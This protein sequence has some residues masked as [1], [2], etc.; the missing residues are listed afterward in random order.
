MKIEKK[1]IIVKDGRRL[2]LRSPE[3]EE[4]EKLLSHLFITHTESYENLDRTAESWKQF[5]VEKEKEIIKN[6]I[7]AK[8]KFFVT[9]FFEE[10]IVGGL[11]VSGD[12]RP[13]R[14]HNATLGMSIQNAFKNKGLGSEMMSYA[15]ENA[16][17]ASL[18]RIDLTVR[19][20]N[21]LAIHL[22]EKLGFQRVGKLIDAAKVDGKFV[23]EYLYQKLI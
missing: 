5:P 9:A 7:D 3:P 19:D 6:F 10:K 11:G 2:T 13:F 17:K 14:N 23:S 15:L 21:E 12:D 4:A 8:N 20:Y 1:E 18:H 16:E 22:Y